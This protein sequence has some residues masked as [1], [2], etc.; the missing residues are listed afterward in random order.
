MGERAGGVGLDG[1]PRGSEGPR[2]PE[3]VQQRIRIVTAS[4]GMKKSVLGFQNA[5]GAVPAECREVAG[6]HAC[7]GGV[8]RMKWFHQGA[9]ILR[10]ARGLAG[11]D[12]EGL[13][14]ELGVVAAQLG[15]GRHAA[16]CPA[17]A[18]R[19]KAVFVIP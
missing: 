9:E 3:F 18:G 2:M 1:D 5:F 7:L 4:V 16:K 8:T 6:N 17:Y 11:G 19:M 15:A 10:Q 13:A 12:R 14:N